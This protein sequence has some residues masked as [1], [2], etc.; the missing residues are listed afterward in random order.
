MSR[1]TFPACCCQCCQCCGEPLLTHTST[2]SLPMLPGNFSSVSCRV[3][4]LFLWVLVCTRICSCPPKWSLCIPQSCG[5]PKTK[6]C[7]TS[8]PDSLGIPQS[9]CQIPR[10]GSLMWGSEPSQQWESF[11]G[12]IILKFVGH[13]ACGY[14]IWLLSW[15][16]PS[17]HLTVISSSSLDVGYLFLMDSSVLLS[18][19]VQQLVAILVLSHKK[20]SAHPSTLPS[21]TGRLREGF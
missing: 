18:L 15:W 16:H 1:G 11:F 12:I 2:G 6:S 3:I 4:A 17:Y 20:M 14:G 9:L 8:S 5:S 13:P 7:C 19:T 21:W 10:L